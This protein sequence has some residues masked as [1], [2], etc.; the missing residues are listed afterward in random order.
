QAHGVTERRLRA[1][2]RERGLDLAPARRRALD[3]RRLAAAAAVEQAPGIHR[4]QSAHHEGER[5][6]PEREPDEMM[7]VE[8][9]AIGRPPAP[10]L[11]DTEPD[12]NHGE[13]GAETRGPDH[14]LA[15]QHDI[16]AQRGEIEPV[17]D[18][19]EPVPEALRRRS[20]DHDPSGGAG[21]IDA[22]A[23]RVVEVE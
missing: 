11:S 14:D 21:N 6:E 12:A 13:K 9:P 1:Q 3:S 10:E 17:R 7:P 20:P 18:R 5:H 4:Q 22:G 2:R 15:P 19:A 23:R 16:A 8:Y